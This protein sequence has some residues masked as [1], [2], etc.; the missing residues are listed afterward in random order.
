MTAMLDMRI[1]KKVANN[2]A[3]TAKP[4]FVVEK[5][6]SFMKRLS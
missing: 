2:G 6:D 3:A 4:I 5:R 1:E